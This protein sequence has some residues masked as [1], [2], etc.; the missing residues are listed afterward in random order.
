VTGTFGANLNVEIIQEQKVITGGIPAEYVGAAGLISTVITKSGSNTYSGS[1]NYF[2]QNNNLVAANKNNP[3]NTFSS[4]DTAYTVGGPILR[5]SLWGFGSY[6]Y[7]KNTQ[8]VNAQDTRA[9]LRTADTIAHQSFAKGTWAPTQRDLISFLW[10]NDPQTRSADTDPSI[11]NSRIR[12]RKQGGNR[13]SGTYQR[14]WSN[15]LVDAA[16]NDHQAELT[17]LAVNQAPRN[18]VAYQRATTRTLADEQLGGFGQNFPEFRPTKQARVFAQYQLGT[19][20][21]KAGYE[22]QQR[23]NDRDLLYVPSSDR[24]QYTSIANIYGSATAAS[25]AN[26]TL[27]ST[28]QFN[29][30][31][32][33]DYV[34]LIN[35]INTLPNRAAFYSQYDTDGNGTITAA[36]LGQSLLFN[37]TAGNPNGMLNYYRITMTNTGLQSQKFRANG[38]YLQDDFRVGAKLAFN[39]GLRAELY[40]HFSTTN[41]SIYQFPWTWAPRLSAAYDIR[42]DGTQKASAYWGRYFD[43]I[44]MDMSNFAGTTSGSTREEQVFINNQWVTYRVR[45]FSPIPDGL[46]APSTKTP[47][48]DELQLQYEI[49]LG[50]NQGASAVYYNRRTRDIFEDW[51]PGIYTRPSSYIGL[52]GRGDP[53]APNSLFLGYDYLG[54]DPANPPVANFFLGTLKGGERNYNG[55]E[56]TYRKRYSDNW[57]AYAAYNYLDAKGNA[58]SDGNADFAGD[59]F[60]LDPRAPNMYGTVPGTIH[61]LFKAAGSYTTRWGLELGGTYSWNSGSIV[62]RTQLASSRRLPVQ[63]STPFLYGGLLEDWV[64]PDAIGAVQNPSWYKL[65]V[66]AR[67]LR[68]IS[69]YTAEFTFDIFNVTDNQGAIRIEDLAAGTGTNP[70]GSPIAWQN[71]RRALIGMRFSF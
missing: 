61:H 8:D 64:A 5:N 11:A 25:I 40:E 59:V 18:T 17:D 56:L 54:F 33:S 71:P 70:F 15:L 3:D 21:L 44:R 31:N 45:G 51:D 19:H 52:D 48:T 38:F 13:F 57:Q 29:V 2:F 26:S 22:W 35:R 69:R 24:S 39:V 37:S 30:N 6:R 49:D 58:V 23:G 68:R 47:Y 14:V 63:V 1:G 4:H 32:A 43:P 16:Y 41:Q 42:G 36:E 66:R 55:L 12:E 65:D 60:W 67:Y 46:F 7:I 50:R 27:W 10:M 53:N 62:N 9:L 20:R 28:R 34:G